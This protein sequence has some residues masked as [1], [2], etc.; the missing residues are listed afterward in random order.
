MPL[1]AFIIVKIASGRFIIIYIG[2][3]QTLDKI[4]I[5]L[6]FLKHPSIIFATS[7][8]ERNSLK[9]AGATSILKFIF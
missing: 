5:K 3:R 9:E 7:F 1:I 6:N 8:A 4:A 2:N